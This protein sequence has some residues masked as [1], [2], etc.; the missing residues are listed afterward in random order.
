RPGSPV[1]RVS[2]AWAATEAP[3]AIRDAVATGSRGGGVDVLDGTRRGERAGG[4]RDGQVPRADAIRAQTYGTRGVVGGHP[5]APGGRAD[6]GAQGLA[7]CHRS[8]RA[9]LLSLLSHA[10]VCVRDGAGRAVAGGTGARDQGWRLYGSEFQTRQR[11]GGHGC[12]PSAD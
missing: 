5:S 8:G 11:R 9:L 6:V 2:R 12:V 10:D 4:D 7:G 3:V 1:A